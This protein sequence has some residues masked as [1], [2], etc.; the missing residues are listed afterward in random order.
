MLRPSK[1]SKSS[2]TL[3]AGVRISVFNCN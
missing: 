2:V 3:H 1:P